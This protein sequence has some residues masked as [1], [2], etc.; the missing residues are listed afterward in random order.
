[1]FNHNFISWKSHTT[2]VQVTP[3]KRHKERSI[4]SGKSHL[5]NKRLIN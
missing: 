5:I 3:D 4:Q 1:M 2:P